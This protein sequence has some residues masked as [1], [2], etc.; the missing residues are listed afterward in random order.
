ME[1]IDVELGHLAHPGGGPHPGVVMIHDVWGVSEHT[2]D[3]GRRLA[4]EGFSVLVLDLYRRM[5]DVQ[6]ANPGAWMRALS[7]P[8]AIADV[9][10]AVD[11]LA[12]HPA[13]RGRK[14]G[15][16]GF[17]MGGMYA[18]LAACACRGLSATVPFYGLLSHQHGILF[19]ENGLDP[20]LKP[21]QPVDAADDLGCPLLA[22]FG[23]ED[24]FIPASDIDS[25]KQRLAKVDQP[26]DVVVY[27]GAG[28]AFMNETRPEVFRPG[29]S[30]DAW[31]R[32]VAFLHEHL[33]D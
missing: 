8:D 11:Y 24:E 21:R 26:S 28:H 16:T 27:P 19:D 5:G 13:S 20:A 30:G 31:A 25:L 15:V 17:C 32:T 9:Q 1:T 23:D 29:V 6:I 7:D 14:V 22:F 4:S 3:L 12:E 33:S 2:R 18:L 10:A